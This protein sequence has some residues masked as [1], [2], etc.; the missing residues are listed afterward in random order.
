MQVHPDHPDYS[1]FSI[2]Y[3][4]ARDFW[5]LG[6]AMLRISSFT[7]DSPAFDDWS[8]LK[9]RGKEHHVIDL[10]S[11]ME[12]ININAAMHMS[13]MGIMVMNGHL[14][15]LPTY[16]CSRIIIEAGAKLGYIAAQDTSIEEK[17][18]RHFSIHYREMDKNHQLG[19]RKNWATV[20]Q[21][22]KLRA[23]RVDASV[24]RVPQIGEMIDMIG[25]HPSLASS[26]KLS[27][28]YGMLCGPVH[29]DGETIRQLAMKI[30]STGRSYSSF[31]QQLNPK[32][33]NQILILSFKSFLVG[34]NSYLQY[35]GNLVNAHEVIRA[36]H[37]FRDHAKSWQRER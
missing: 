4:F 32:F 19:D 37:S 35:T 17:L 20:A 23:E 36:E 29:S 10:V 2:W 9:D 22:I 30:A 34:F 3:E 31:D 27:K 5:D 15:D 7:E 8:H 1:Q 14:L 24:K 12:L 25:E 26:E 33:V 21:E 13:A 11:M 6:Q 16:S 18:T 28:I